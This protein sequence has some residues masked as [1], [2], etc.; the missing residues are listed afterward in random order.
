[1]NCFCIFV[2]LISLLFFNFFYFSVVC[3]MSWTGVGGSKAQQDSYGDV[4][5]DDHLAD[6]FCPPDV[7]AEKG[8]FC[9]MTFYY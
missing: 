8:F 3:T 5:K 4:E 6:V 1:M 9:G 7:V 2:V